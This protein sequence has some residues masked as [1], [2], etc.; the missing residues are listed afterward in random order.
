MKVEENL[1]LTKLYDAY[2]ALLSIGQQEIMKSYLYDDLTVS[3]IAE[4]LSV[5]RQAVKDSITKA[6]KKLDSFEQKLSIVEKL[7]NLEGENEKLRK[8]LERLKKKKI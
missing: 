3:E 5:S 2:G 8:E 6:E 4:N 1:R 7:D